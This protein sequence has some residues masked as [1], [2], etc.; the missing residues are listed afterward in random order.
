MR[1][2]QFEYLASI[3]R[4]KSIHAASRE[5]LVSQQCISKAMKDFE[6]ELNA[7]LFFRSSTGTVLTPEGEDVYLHALNI[8][9]E[10]NFLNE[11]YKEKQTTERFFNDPLKI[12]ISSNISNYISTEINQF[13]STYN[14][15]IHIVEKYPEKIIDTLSNNMDCEFALVQVPI[16]E[17]QKYNNIKEKFSCFILKNEK[18]KLFLNKESEYAHYSSISLRTLKDIPLYVTVTDEGKYPLL[19]QVL[20]DRNVDLNIKILTSERNSQKYIEENIAGAL[21]TGLNFKLMGSPSYMCTIPLKEKIYLSTC[22]LVRKENI[23]P[24][25]QTFITYLLNK[26]NAKHIF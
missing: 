11:C 24:V 19:I 20:M 21:G 14:T 7:K 22:L 4:N 17:L 25:S 13:Y 18:V 23:S 5:L 15:K 1:L 10:V 16:S 6:E 2:E 3:K 8:L 26:K 12:Y 9:K